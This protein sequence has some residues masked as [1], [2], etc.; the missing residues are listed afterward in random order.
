MYKPSNPHPLLTLNSPQPVW[1]T[2]PKLCGDALC[3]SKNG[4]KKDRANIKKG[5]IISQSY[6]KSGQKPKSHENR[7]KNVNPTKCSYKY[8]IWFKMGV[9]K[10]ERYVDHHY[11]SQESCPMMFTFGMIAATSRDGSFI[12]TD[13]IIGDIQNIYK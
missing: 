12:N 9:T 11:C 10:I 3:E 4:T 13:Y 6:E 8:G 7:A 1:G 5:V 2:R